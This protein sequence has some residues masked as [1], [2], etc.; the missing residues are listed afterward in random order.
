MVRKSAF[1][2]IELLVVIAIIAILIGML[3]PA[4]QKVREASSKMACS[5]NLKQLA[6][7]MHN[8]QSTFNGLPVAGHLCCN[9]TWQVYM[10]P[11]I[12]QEAAF[13]LYQNLGGNDTTGIRYD[14]GANVANVTGKRFKVFTCPSD[15]PSMFGGSISNHNYVVNWGNTFT[16]QGDIGAV[17]FGG[18]PFAKNRAAKVNDI[19][20]GLSNTLMF[21][22]INQGQ[23]TPNS[24]LRGLTWWSDAAHFTAYNTPNTPAPDHL[25][26]IRY[27]NPNPPNAPCIRSTGVFPPMMA[28]RSRHT[29]GVNVAFFD[30]AVAF[31]SNNITVGVWRAMSTSKGGEV[32]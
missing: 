13:K 17:I 22:E 29:G 31:I 25:S 19:L 12:E 11:Y 10:L 26:D 5:N 8:Y 6:T 18:A 15:L 20:D 1:T 32:Y 3:L 23:T 27:C 7:A 16:G 24:D 14:G 28:A 9:G 21:S 30:G 2:L 4:V